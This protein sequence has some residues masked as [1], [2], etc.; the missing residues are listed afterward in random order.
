METPRQ[1]K[2]SFIKFSTKYQMYKL[3]IQSIREFNVDHG[4]SKRKISED[5]KSRLM[6]GKLKL[7]E[8]MARGV[9]Q[10]IR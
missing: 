4:I 1:R 6:I 8:N 2:K 9:I 5:V 10:E 3:G 7:T